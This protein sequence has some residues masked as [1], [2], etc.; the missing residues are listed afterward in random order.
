MPSPT[1]L[2]DKKMYL[3]KKMSSLNP[4]ATFLT[5]NNS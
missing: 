4:P 1:Y 3:F 5:K 2:G